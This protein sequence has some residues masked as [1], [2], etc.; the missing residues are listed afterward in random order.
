MVSLFL[1]TK[2]PPIPDGLRKREE[3]IMFGTDCQ[4]CCFS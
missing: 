4:D 1:S 3:E 2:R